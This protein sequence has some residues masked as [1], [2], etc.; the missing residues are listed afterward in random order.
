MDAE[1]A[2]DHPMMIVCHEQGARRQQQQQQAG[3]AAE[4]PAASAASASGSVG[5]KETAGAARG[6][7]QLAAGSAVPMQQPPSPG[8][9]VL[10]STG[11]SSRA[12]GP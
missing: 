6:K 4:G 12:H 8:S 10:L 9:S 7:P 11:Y 5:S 2:A 3:P 1:K